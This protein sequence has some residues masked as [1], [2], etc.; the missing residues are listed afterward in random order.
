ML[1]RSIIVPTTSLVHQL[2]SDFGD[3]GYNSDARVHTI[4]SGQDKQT[5]KPV[6]ISTWQSLYKLPKDYFSQFEVIIGD[7]AHLFK[8][9][10]LT[11]IMS[12]LEN[13]KYRFG[14]TGTLDGTQT[15]KLVLEGLFGPVRKITT[16]SELIEQKILSD[17]RI[18]AIVL[19]YPDEI[20]KMIIRSDYQNEID[21]IVRLQARNNFIR[22]LVLSLEGN[23]LLLFQFVEK[24]GKALYDM[25]NANASDRKIF[26]IH[27]GTEAEVREQ[28]RK[29]VENEEIGRAH[30]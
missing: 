23:T 24:H 22:N 6:T 4:F 3:Y 25:I 7:E 1:F 8:A 29:I 18:K 15:H 9:K 13:T 11:S 14:F 2:A 10:S 5:N 26:F 21:Y 12:K 16:T 19:S 28:T 20:R 27:G 17:F 30:V